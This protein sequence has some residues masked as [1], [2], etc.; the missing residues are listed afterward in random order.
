MSRLPQQIRKVEVRDR[1]TGRQVIR[2]EVRVDAGVNASGQR[3]QTKRR[4]ATEKEARDALSEV[5][6]QG[7]SGTFVPKAA[8]TVE[9]AC[10][11]Y[12]AGLH[13][14]EP[15]TRAAYTFA[16]KP[17]RGRHG[18]LP[19]QALTKKHLDELVTDLADGSFPGLKKPWTANS[20][21]PMLN[22]LSRML[23]DLV[24]QGTIARDVAA[25]VKRSKRPETTLT[26][27]TEHEVRQLLAHVKN[28]RLGVAWH[29]ALTGLR[30]GE[31]SGLL[32][33][34]VALVD[35]HD[36]G[37]LTIAHNRVSVSGKVHNKKPK[38]KRS[39]R[40]LPL[41]PELAKTLRR[42]KATQAAEHLRLGAAYLD[43]DHVDSGHVVV[44]ETGR[45]YHPDTLSDFWRELCGAAKVPQ[46]RL[47]DARHT[48][49]T[50]MALQNVPIV[51][52]SAW[53][54]HA[55]PAFTMRTYV[56]SQNDALTAAATSLQSVVSPLCH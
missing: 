37:T 28:D 23:A 29:L 53:L 3:R 9:Q 50:L 18:D 34:D 22:L 48:C 25:M 55:D 30:R 56:H 45:P 19:V 41:T 27:F 4:F 38:T 51:V 54:G 14:I 36:S 24:T 21:N 49:A 47:H 6:A 17:L 13:D 52:V 16:L 15:T 44:D 8:L 42:A 20:V 12:L 26:T 1:K 32:W 35:G 31:I 10:V 11:D 7:R 43:S 40:T 33:S 39:A 46:I 2:Y 5:D